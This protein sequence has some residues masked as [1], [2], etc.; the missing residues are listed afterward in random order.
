MR[1]MVLLVL[2]LLPLAAPSLAVQPDEMLADPVLEARARELSQGLRCLVCR[3][4][5]IDES[6]ADLAR[7]LRLLVRER[8]VAG[9]SDAEAIAYLVDRYGEYVL[10]RPTASG[11]NLILWIAGPVMFLLALAGA[12]MY[13]RRRRATADE[14]PR[15]LSE[16]E[17]AR[18]REILGK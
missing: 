1:V 9:D 17:T 16:A 7:D 14:P 15:A 5:N 6:N 12:G 4:E 10:L 11:S 8:L 3:N 13:L 2:L 18:L